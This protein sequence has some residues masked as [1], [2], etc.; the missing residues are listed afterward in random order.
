MQSTIDL[1]NAT[2]T[3]LMRIIRETTVVAK[4]AHSK[5]RDELALKL[6]R[7]VMSAADCGVQVRKWRE[8]VSAGNLS[9]DEDALRAKCAEFLNRV[10]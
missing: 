2:E 8:R 5:G 7:S 4:L 3:A 9:I 6:F 10:R 1:L